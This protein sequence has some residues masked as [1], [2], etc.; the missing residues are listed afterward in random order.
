MNPVENGKTEVKDK[1]VIAQEEATPVVKEDGTEVK[2]TVN[3]VL[4]AM[5]EATGETVTADKITTVTTTTELNKDLVSDIVNADGTVQQVKDIVSLPT[6][7]V[8]IYTQ[9]EGEVAQ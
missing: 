1:D 7:A 3:D 6:S 9:N 4:D 8:V 5:E 2:V